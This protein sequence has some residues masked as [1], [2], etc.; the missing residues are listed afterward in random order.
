MRINQYVVKVL[1]V[2]IKVVVRRTESSINSKVEHG[3]YDNQ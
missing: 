2:V 3:D 1:L